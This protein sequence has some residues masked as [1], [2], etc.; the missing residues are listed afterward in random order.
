MAIT[1]ADFDWLARGWELGDSWCL[2]FVRGLDEAEA[3]RRLGAAEGSIRPLTYKRMTDEGL[4]PRTVLAGHLDGWT[5]LIE[6]NGSEATAPDAVRA[7]S[8]GTE[9]ISVLRNDYATDLFVYAVDGERLTSFDPRKPAWRYG[10]DPDRLLNA[11]R[12]EGVDPSY[13]RPENDS[14]RDEGGDDDI[15]AGAPTLNDALMLAARVTGVALSQNVL[16]GPL[17]GGAVG[18]QGS[19]SHTTL[20]LFAA[21]QQDPPRE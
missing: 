2:T 1:H 5:V 3:L 10:T 18:P 9:L 15:S 11:M 21:I 7:L 12:E 4:F 8:A 20:D 17:M 6:R 19:I 14:A 16:N 13:P